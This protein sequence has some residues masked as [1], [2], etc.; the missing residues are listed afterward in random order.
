MPHS[1][2]TKGSPRYSLSLIMD[3]HNMKRVVKLPRM[4]YTRSG[5]LID[6]WPHAIVA[7]EDCW[8]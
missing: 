8:P 1:V 2:A 6:R 3:E 4:M 5:L 7:S